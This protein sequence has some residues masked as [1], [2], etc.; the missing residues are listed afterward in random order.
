LARL[1]DCRSPGGEKKVRKKERGYSIGEGLSVIAI[2]G[3]ALLVSIPHALSYLSA[4]RLKAA[5]EQVATAIQFTRSKAVQQNFVCTFNLILGSPNQFQVRG[6]EDDRGDGL[7]PWEDRNGNGITDTLTFLPHSLPEGTY[8][9]ESLGHL[10]PVNVQG[11]PTNSV[12]EMEFSPLGVPRR[13]SA[14]AIY[15]ENSKKERSAITVDLTGR[16][17]TWTYENS[18]WYQQ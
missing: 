15:L 16:V 5:T 13:N 12:L 8:V 10:P 7:N 6:G 11:R 17:Q 4:Y 2:A 3:M 14:G 18:G 1:L 9:L